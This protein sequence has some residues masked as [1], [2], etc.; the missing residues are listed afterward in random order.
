[1][2]YVS[3][4]NADPGPEELRRL[5]DQWAATYHED[6][7]G[8]SQNYVAPAITAQA[9]L[10][11]LGTDH[12]DPDLE[13]L[14]AGCGTGWVGTKLAQVGAKRID[15]ND[16]SPGMLKVARETGVYRHLNTVDLTKPLS[17]PTGTY[18]VVTCIGTFLLG[19]VGPEALPEFV[20]ILKTGGIV[21][22]TVRDNVWEAKGYKA[23]ID[24]LV[25]EG[26]IKLISAQIS[27]YRK[28]ANIEA[29]LVIFSKIA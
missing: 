7:T 28:G 21:V 10:K 27:D 19:H 17:V 13:I 14:D 1:M 15:G 9:V 26:K 12:I 16:I 3:K 8:D 5:Y 6:L 18:D 4:I 29:F 2:S 11:T 24:K 22:A 23:T 25:Q 20:R